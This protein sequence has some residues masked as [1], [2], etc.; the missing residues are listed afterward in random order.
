[1][2]LRI[3]DPQT[4]SCLLSESPL[5]HLSFIARIANERVCTAG[6]GLRADKLFQLYT[7]PPFPK[8]DASP[9]TVSFPEYD[10]L[11]TQEDGL[12]TPAPY[13]RS[14]LLGGNSSWGV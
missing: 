5:V 4:A 11:A 1:M 6:D 13:I 10:T 9:D 7:D 14:L 3:K 2:R 8:I 12:V